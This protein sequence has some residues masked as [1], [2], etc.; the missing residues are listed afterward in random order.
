L[1]NKIDLVSAEQLAEVKDKLAR[2][3]EQASIL[4]T[5]RCRVD[6]DL[7]FGSAHAH[8]VSPP[9]H[10]HQPEVESFSYVSEAPL[11]RG[12]FEEFADR[13][14]P[15]VWRAKGF[16][17]FPEETYLFNFVAGRWELEFVAEK[18]TTLVFIGEHVTRHQADL[19]N[20][21]KQCER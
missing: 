19:V 1:L 21:L 12:C 18:P 17:R 9:L 6:P 11:E 15:T 20:E 7:L 14:S 16:V 5:Q 10:R 13:L 4:P 8:E 2:L 3:N